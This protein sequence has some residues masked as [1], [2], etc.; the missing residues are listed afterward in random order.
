[1]SLQDELK[2]LERKISDFTVNL[3]K[4]DIPPEEQLHRSW[5]LFGREALDLKERLGKE[6][7]PEWLVTLCDFGQ[8]NGL[9]DEQGQAIRSEKAHDP[10][11]DL[12]VFTEK[13]LEKF[14]YLMN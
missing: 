4:L 9:I 2:N 5:N 11:Q 6:E 10:M 12:G 1:M 13:F 3:T 7:A 14:P 8:D